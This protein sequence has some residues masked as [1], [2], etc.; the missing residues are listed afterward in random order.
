MQATLDERVPSSKAGYGLE[1]GSGGFRGLGQSLRG[2][3]RPST[4]Q[5]NP[6]GLG[7]FLSSARPQARKVGTAHPHPTRRWAVPT[8]QD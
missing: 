8:L 3:L 5:K 4:F 6:S 1:R 2:C 7:D